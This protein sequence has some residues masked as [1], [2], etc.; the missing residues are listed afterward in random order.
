MSG[1][2]G[3]TFI[4]TLRNHYGTDFSLNQDPNVRR[5]KTITR[6]I[7]ISSERA[8]YLARLRHMTVSSKSL[9]FGLTEYSSYVPIG[10]IIMVART[11]PSL[12][13]LRKAF[14]LQT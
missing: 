13:I 1:K 7:R 8:I 3:N 6:G 10:T 5:R 4:A 2:P 9:T 14:Q 11:I 12:M